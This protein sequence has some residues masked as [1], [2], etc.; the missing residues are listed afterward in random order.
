MTSTMAVAVT[1]LAG[2]VLIQTNRPVIGGAF[3]ESSATWR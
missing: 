2:I 1:M 3:A